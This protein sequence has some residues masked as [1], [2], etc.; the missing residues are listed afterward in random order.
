MTEQ[1]LTFLVAVGTAIG[2]FAVL[3]SYG[4]K[5]A[6][7]AVLLWEARV[8]LPRDE[9]AHDDAV[10]RRVRRISAGGVGGFLGLMVGTLGFL[11]DPGMIGLA[12][13]LICGMA[14]TTWATWRWHSADLRERGT[15]ATSRAA[16]LRRRRLL[17]YLTPGEVFSPYAVLGIPAAVVVHGV[18]MLAS[19]APQVGRAIALLVVAVLSAAVFVAAKVLQLRALRLV[20][21]AGSASEMRWEEAQR[22][23]LLRELNILSIVSPILL[24]GLVWLAVSH[25]W[26]RGVPEP[27]DQLVQWTWLVAQYSTFWAIWSS[28]RPRG[29][30]RSQRQFETTEV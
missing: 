3:L 11:I 4:P 9:A 14:G 12:C 13:A 21:P 18:I 26:L 7:N 25:Q 5:Q 17:D 28:S 19:D 23:L 24:G 8:G 29:L 16:A 10:L 30:R 6:E 22:A 20:H 27:L 1:E 2:L 15:Q